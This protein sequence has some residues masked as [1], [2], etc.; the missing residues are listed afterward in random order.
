MA[1]FT[2]QEIEEL[3]EARWKSSTIARYCR[4]LEVKD[5]SEKNQALGLLKEFIQNDGSWEELEFYVKT[6]KS[7]ESENLILD[8]IIEQKKEID[9]H[10]VDLS[11]I[12]SINDMLRKE[13]TKWDWFFKYFNLVI[14]VIN[15]GYSL[16]E[17]EALKQKTLEWGG[18]DSVIRNISYALTE[19]EVHK[20]INE[21]N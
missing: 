14:N 6:K 2:P 5:T 9:Y 13:N 18:F 10:G 16:S 8:D 1:G 15:L 7:L 19:A 21:T 4:E 17:L 20:K 11:I 3:T 12:G